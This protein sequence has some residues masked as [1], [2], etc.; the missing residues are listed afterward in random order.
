[1]S[2]IQ[3]IPS[4]TTLILEKL[5]NFRK[6]RERQSLRVHKVS[7]L[8]LQTIKGRK[9]KFKLFVVLK[10]KSA[11]PP[12]GRPR[13]GEGYGGVCFPVSQGTT[14]EECAARPVTPPR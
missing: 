5:Q 3:K 7:F 1:M 13:T 11:Y 6:N 8:H 4:H 12:G 2:M 14:P 9:H 10:Q